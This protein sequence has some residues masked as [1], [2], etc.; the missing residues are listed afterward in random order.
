MS[1]NPGI[2]TTECAA[3]RSPHAPLPRLVFGGCHDSQVVTDATQFNGV[4][5][6]DPDSDICENQEGG[7]E[8]VPE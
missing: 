1:S 8:T 2:T 3:Y 5:V 7:Y 4:E 6:E